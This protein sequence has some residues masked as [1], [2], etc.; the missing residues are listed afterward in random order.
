MSRSWLNQ[1]NKK[2]LDVQKK[3]FIRGG[4]LVRKNLGF[5]GCKNLGFLGYKKA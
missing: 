2:V 1:V 3:T 5:L 4:K